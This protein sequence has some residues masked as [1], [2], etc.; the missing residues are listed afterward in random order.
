MLA[1]ANAEPPSGTDAKRM[2]RL[3][4]ANSGGP[5]PSVKLNVVNGVALVKVRVPPGYGPPWKLLVTLVSPDGEMKESVPGPLVAKTK[6][7]LL[8]GL[9]KASVNMLPAFPNSS[10]RLSPENS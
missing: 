8:T 10:K 1:I 5:S 4:I 6:R 2:V 3:S 9:L 7:T